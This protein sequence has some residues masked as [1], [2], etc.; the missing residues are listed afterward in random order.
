MVDA[1][2]YISLCEHMYETSRRGR[3]AMHAAP[4]GV[5]SAHRRPEHRESLRV[6]GADVQLPNLPIDW[7]LELI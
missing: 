5:A 2:A 6:R 1:Y 4:T 7:L 3:V